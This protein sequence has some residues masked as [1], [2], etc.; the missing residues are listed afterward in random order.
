MD[1][2]GKPVTDEE[3]IQAPHL[4]ESEPIVGVYTFE[5]KDG[6]DVVFDKKVISKKS[7]GK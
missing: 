7:K 6:E 5:I 3:N 2:H 4:V 1:I